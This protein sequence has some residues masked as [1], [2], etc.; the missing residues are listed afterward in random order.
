MNCWVVIPLQAPVPCK[1]RLDAVL[2][3]AQRRE[4]TA[5]LRRTA[6]GA[7]S[8]VVGPCQVCLRGPSADGL[9]GS[10]MRLGHP[11][12]GLNHAL[13]KACDAA[14]DA[15]VDRLVLSAD[16]PELVPDDIEALLDQTRT[17][18]AAAPDRP[19]RGTN[20]L[21]LPLPEATAYQFC[22]GPKS[23]AA[24][25]EVAIRHGLS[26]VAVERARLAFDIDWPADLAEWRGRM[27]VA[28]QLLPVISSSDPDPWE[29]SDAVIV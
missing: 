27:S 8:A 29:P 26:F 7:A 14:L 4:L 23:F 28:P 15:K 19:G 9:D 3:E 18:V 17:A 2:D 12:S 1:R 24:H 21:S 16:L 20:A 5:E 22:F 6:V 10:T 13:R 11:G 25:R